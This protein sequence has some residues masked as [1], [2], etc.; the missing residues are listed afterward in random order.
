MKSTGRKWTLLLLMT[1]LSIS[2]LFSCGKGLTGE[3]EQGGGGLLWL[4]LMNRQ[5]ETG[6]SFFLTIPDGVAK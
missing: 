6:P 1:L 2:L 3:E 5:S 4:L